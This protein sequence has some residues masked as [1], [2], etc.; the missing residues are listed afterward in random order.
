MR[1]HL[2]DRVD[3]LEP[4]LSISARKLTSHRET[5]WRDD[6]RGPEMPPA[7]VFEALCQAGT[8]LVMLST[9]LERRA[10]LLS[11]DVL[12]FHGPVRPGD[13]LQLEGQVESMDPDTAVLS[14]SVRVGGRTVLEA[15]AIMCALMP[16]EDLEELVDVRMMSRQLTSATVRVAA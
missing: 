8:W 7:L 14:G 6:G 3:R 2:I 15:D 16:T 4:R 10:A 1:F 12:R 11:V 9:D 13:V 5:Y